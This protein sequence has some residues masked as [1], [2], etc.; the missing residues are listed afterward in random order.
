[1]TTIEIRVHTPAENAIRP[2]P[3]I[4]NTSHRVRLSCVVVESS[5]QMASTR[6]MLKHVNEKQERLNMRSLKR[7]EKSGSDSVAPRGDVKTDVWGGETMRKRT[8]QS[9]GG[10]R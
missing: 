1:M 9:W 6:L 3:A 8:F 7:P 4:S 2:M 10:R 5:L